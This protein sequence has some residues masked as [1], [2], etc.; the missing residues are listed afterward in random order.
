MPSTI[1][2]RELDHTRC[3][4]R[5]A[6]FP[7]PYQMKPCSCACHTEGRLFSAVSVPQG[8]SQ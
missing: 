5:V 1:V 7:D 6:D 3:Q 2:C 4:G 8:D